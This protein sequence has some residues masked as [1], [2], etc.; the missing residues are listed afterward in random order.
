M[1]LYE[2]HDNGTEDERVSTEKNSLFLEWLFD[3]GKAKI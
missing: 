2:F 1:E 3:T